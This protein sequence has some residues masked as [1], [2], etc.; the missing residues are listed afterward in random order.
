MFIPPN[1]FLNKDRSFQCSLSHSQ[2]T[3]HA[4]ATFLGSL[5]ISQRSHRSPTD[6]LTGLPPLHYP[7]LFPKE[8]HFIPP[9]KLPSVLETARFLILHVIFLQGQ[10]IVVHTLAFKSP[11]PSAKHWGCHPAG[12]QDTSSNQQPDWSP[13]PG[14][15]G[16]PAMCGVL[17][18][19]GLSTCLG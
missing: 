6:L 2:A 8:V 17:T 3:H 1:Q 15:Q 7:D 16:S 14:A 4:P 19:P 11:G 18:P 12:P 5:P 9:P 10:N 13:E